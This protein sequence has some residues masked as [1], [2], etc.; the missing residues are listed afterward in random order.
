M[1]ITKRQREIFDCLADGLTNPQI[2]LKLGISTP[3]VQ[4]LL[5]TLYLL[6]ETSNKHHLVAW[7]Y[8]NG[9]LK[10]ENE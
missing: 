6:T 3:Y 5:N 2:A 4:N 8:K 1:V 9:V 10:G 7:A